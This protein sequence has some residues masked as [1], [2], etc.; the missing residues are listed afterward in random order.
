M[1]TSNTRQAR[2]AA[3]LTAAHQRPQKLVLPT[4]HWA[5]LSPE[6]YEYQQHQSM[7]QD[8]D[9]ATGVDAR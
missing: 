1:D 7:Y 6:I 8:S 4:A 9:A 5:L 3:P 2:D